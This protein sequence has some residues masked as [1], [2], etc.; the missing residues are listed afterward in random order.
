MFFLHFYFLIKCIVAEHFLP[1]PT[2]ELENK[3]S[4]DTIHRITNPKTVFVI[5]EDRE[6]VVGMSM[7][8]ALLLTAMISDGISFI[9]I[10]FD[11]IAITIK[12]IYFFL[13]N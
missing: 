1:H 13:L 7:M 10:K 4:T 3:N 12:F 9:H 8:S 6:F 11:L 2:R 5:A